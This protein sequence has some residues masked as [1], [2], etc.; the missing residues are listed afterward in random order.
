MN[1]IITTAPPANRSLRTGAKF[2]F[3]TLL[4]MHFPPIPSII[5]SLLMKPLPLILLAFCAASAH[6]APITQ[7]GAIDYKPCTESSGVV[8]SRQFPGVFWTHCDSGNEAA[9]YAITKEGK[10]L[11]EYRVN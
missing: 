4:K 8:A 5:S 2:T 3:F 7:I 11:A 9:I 6:A 10:F 1:K